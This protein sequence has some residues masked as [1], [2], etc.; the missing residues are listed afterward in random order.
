MAV[1][2]EFGECVLNRSAHELY[3]NGEPV[4]LRSQLFRLLCA[5][6]DRKG[7]VLTNEQLIQ[8]ISRKAF[9]TNDVCTQAIKDLRRALGG[10]SKDVVYIETKLR[11]GYIF[12]AEVKILQTA[13]DEGKAQDLE[14]TDASF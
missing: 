5:F 9:V 10:M 13:S 3:R 12:V 11:E 7:E 8:I 14:L 2:Y 4:K 1:I 6:L